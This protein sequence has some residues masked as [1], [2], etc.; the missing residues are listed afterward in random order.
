MKKL[1]EQQIPKHAMK[2]KDVVLFIMMSMSLSAF[3]EKQHTLSS[4]DKR[5]EICI[6]TDTQL[7]WSVKMDNKVVLAPSR[8]GFQLEDGKILGDDCASRVKRQSIDETFNTPFYRKASVIDRYNQLIVPCGKNV[9]AEFRAY[10][11]GVACRFVVD[12]KKPVAVIKDLSEFIFPMDCQAYI[13]YIND[14]RGNDPY[15]FSFES[16]YDRSTL[17]GMHADSLAITP[18][19]LELQDNYKVLLM[20][21]DIE[22]FAGMFLKKGDKSHSLLP[23]YAPCVLEGKIGGFNELNYIPTKRAE[24]IAVLEGKC[25]L[26]WKALVLSRE[27]KELANTD[28]MLRLSSPCRLEDTSWIKPGKTAWEWWNSCN[29][30]GVPFKRGINTETYKYYID[31]AAEQHLEY[32]L[33]DD[34]WSLPN[35]MLEVNPDINLPELAAYAQSKNVGL[36]LWASWKNLIREMDEAF[37]RY[38]KMG[39]KGFKIDF[40]D[41]DDH[42]MVKDMYKIAERAADY[43]FILSYHGMKANGMQ[44]TYPNIL[45]FE[46]VKGLENYRWIS[47]HDVPDYECTLPFMRM[48]AGPM[49]YTPGGMRNV[50]RSCF[51]PVNDQPRVYGTRAHQVALYTLFES[52]LQMLSDSPTTYMEEDET[53]AFIKQIPTVFD[54]TVV[55]DAEVG[56]HIIVAKRK[57]DVWYIGGITDWDARSIDINLNFLPE[58]N[59]RAQIFS[60]GINA[61]F[62]ATDY[63]YTEQD[64]QSSDRLQI[65]MQP[66]GGWAAILRP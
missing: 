56:N 58:G 42:R 41:S 20:D 57:G 36:V 62:D 10:N 21:A 51:S 49:D 31:F 27:D 64:V 66:G 32:M 60:D 12:Y 55:L 44:R 2:R 37:E 52:P 15:M 61:D 35:S 39:I 33:I 18:F 26:P 50:N 43:H 40:F 9:F 16:Y 14:N 17:S 46:G 24:Y 34:G 47:R 53:L 7:Q 11:D 48:Q 6:D 4:P 8:L 59:Y 13:P 23:A 29:L 3:A 38:S 54:E 19:L 5:I 25:E 63:I 65:H 30:K 28:M 45:S 22:D 1:K